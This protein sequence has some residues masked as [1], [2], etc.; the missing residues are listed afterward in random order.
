M[1]ERGTG[2]KE[3]IPTD[4]DKERVV[5]VSQWAGQFG[6]HAQRGYV[7]HQP[8]YWSAIGPNDQQYSS[9]VSAS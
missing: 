5:A 7:G 2:S 6:R 3:R 1:R 9:G 4:H 8:D